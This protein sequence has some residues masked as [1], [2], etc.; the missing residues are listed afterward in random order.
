MQLFVQGQSVHTL[1]VS[2]EATVDDI[3]EALAGLEGIS[4]DDQVLSYGGLP[5]DEDCLVLDTVPE[6]GTIS[7]SI[8]VLGGIY[9]HIPTF[10]CSLINALLHIL[11]KVHG[12]LA[13]AGKVRGQT[14]KVCAMS[15]PPLNIVT[16][17]HYSKS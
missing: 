11:G 14:P 9:M 16:P 8:R 13:R 7:L 5:L 15:I 2:Q 10:E 17:D 12:S 3:K 6:H 4:C 1:N